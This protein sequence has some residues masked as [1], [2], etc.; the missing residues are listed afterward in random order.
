METLASSGLA[1]LSLSSCL[2]DLWLISALAS[3]D[4]KGAA[5]AAVLRDMTDMRWTILG[6]YLLSDLVFLT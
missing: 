4:A 2:P 1:S 3:G 6:L 5:A